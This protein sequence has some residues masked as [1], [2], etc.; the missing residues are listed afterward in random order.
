MRPT[1][2][3]R[4]TAVRLAGV[5]AA[6]SLVVAACGDDDEDSTS[7]EA[8]AATEALA[9]SEA[10]ADSAA[11]ADTGGGEAAAGPLSDVCP[12][13]LV[14][15]TDWFPEAEHGA[16]YQLLGSEYE[17]DTSA[18]TVTGPMILSGGEPA[19]IDLEIRT[20]GPAI[21]FSPV[22]AQMYTDTAIHL[23]YVSTDEA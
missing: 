22:S 11:P 13:P 3:R 5:I 8:P 19:G 12:S 17:I 18:K 15:Q 2:T 23:G 21:G 16:L 4:R 20:G 9:A 14:I 6:A 7:T 10:P 1:S